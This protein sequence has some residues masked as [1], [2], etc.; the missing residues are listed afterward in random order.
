MKQ[1]LSA[2]IF[3]LSK[4]TALGLSRKVWKASSRLLSWAS[5]FAVSRVVNT[6]PWSWQAAFRS[7]KASRRLFQCHHISK[8]ALS[9]GRD[10]KLIRSSSTT[11]A[12]RSDR[13]KR[14]VW[15]GSLYHQYHPAARVWD[16]MTQLTDRHPHSFGSLA[17]PAA[18]RMIFLG[19]LNM[20][21]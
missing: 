12:P 11:T 17:I 10:T 19:P 2:V 6:S 16:Q 1:E 3:L 20:L 18:D 8:D 14:R 5:D 15:W 13:H 7:A 9:P 4:L 21:S